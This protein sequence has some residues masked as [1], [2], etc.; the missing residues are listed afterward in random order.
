MSEAAYDGNLGFE[1]LMIFQDKATPAQRAQLAK[2]LDAGKNQEALGMLQKVVGYDLAPTGQKKL[3]AYDFDNTLATTN[4]KTVVH[5][6]DGSSSEFDASQWPNYEEQ[7]GDKVDYSQF[8]RLVDPEKIPQMWSRFEKDVADVNTDVVIVTARQHEAAPEIAKFLQNNGVDTGV[9]IRTL[10]SGK[11]V[12]KA[13][14]MKNKILK[15]GYDFVEFFDDHE[16]NTDIVHQL[17]DD[18]DIEAEVMTHT[19]PPEMYIKKQVTDIEQHLK[20]RGVDLSKVRVHLDRDNQIATFP[21]YN[22]SGQMVGYQRYNP[23][24]IKKRGNDLRHKYY[25]YIAPEGDKSKLAV[26]GSENIDPKNP[27]LYATEGIFDA[28]KLMNA[29]L[30]VIATLTNDPKQL[31]S[32]FGALNKHIV[33]VTDN[34]VAGKKLA[35]YGDEH[36]T[37]PDGHNDLGDMTQEEVNKFVEN[38]GHTPKKGVEDKGVEVLPVDSP[39]D[40]SQVK[41][42]VKKNHYI[43]KWP[44]AVQKVMGVYNNGELVGTVVYGIFANPSFTSRIFQDDS[45]Q[46]IMKNNQMWELQRLFLDPEAQKTIPNL[47]SMAIS[48]GNEYIRTGAKTKDGEPVKAIISLAN[49][50]VGHS[51]VVYKA[52]NAL[53][54]GQS[55]SGKHNFLYPLGKDQKERDALTS[56]IVKQLYSYPTEEDPGGKPIPN[57]AK[58]KK[59]RAPQQQ[60][61][62]KQKA[63]PDQSRAAFFQDILNRTVKN[64]LTGNM[65]KVSTALG[66]EKN[67]PSYRQAQ[68]MMQSLAK[69]AGIGLSD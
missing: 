49:P 55:R 68:G 13:R 39:E 44:T 36:Y 22:L 17:N 51:G 48:R 14:Y 3:A 69:K 58:E 27:N 59:A 25:S 54:M 15:G 30:P 2:L 65:I 5:H 67:H 62:S 38:I 61:Q 26:W 57:T 4:S 33:V 8:D 7:P 64:P 53:Y 24:G 43:N 41:D 21:L 31:K 52:T 45:G 11:P 50:D 16:G 12:A 66:Y 34:D 46:P 19:V 28:I 10:S 20:D 35:K 1:E 29:G 63:A 18:P 9:R 40:V 32:L 47:A 23:N 56:H 37:V 60:A 42:W 6:A